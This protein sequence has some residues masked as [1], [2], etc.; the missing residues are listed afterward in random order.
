M[1]TKFYHDNKVLRKN[2]TTKTKLYL[3][4]ILA[5]FLLRKKLSSD[6]GQVN[7][8]SSWSFHCPS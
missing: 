3:L 8:F 7:N 6:R 1:F 5:T 2:C 4:I